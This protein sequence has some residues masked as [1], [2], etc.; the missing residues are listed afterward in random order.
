MLAGPLQ[1]QSSPFY[2]RSYQVDAEAI[3]FYSCQ[4]HPLRSKAT[5]YRL[6]VVHAREVRPVEAGW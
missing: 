5:V 2:C 1:P 3:S 6:Q 4:E